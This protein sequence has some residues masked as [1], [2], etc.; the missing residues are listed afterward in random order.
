MMDLK[1]MA[2]GIALAGSLGIAALGFGAGLANAEPSPVPPQ[3]ATAQDS[4]QSGANPQPSPY[5]VYGG[6]DLCG[7]P[8]MYF[9]S[10]CT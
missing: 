4:G 8:G 3:V 5:A 1:T 7:M 2:G 6:T 10:V 9:T